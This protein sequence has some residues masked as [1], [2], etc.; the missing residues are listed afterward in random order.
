MWY[1]VPVAAAP[2]NAYHKFYK[3]KDETHEK[4]KSFQ[5]AY[6]RFGKPVFDFF[7]RHPGDNFERWGGGWRL[8]RRN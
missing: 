4:V 5:A 1:V 6:C 7:F 8:K 2:E 3:E